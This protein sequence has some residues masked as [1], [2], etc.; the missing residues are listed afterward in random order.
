M[1]DPGGLAITRITEFDARGR[2]VKSLMPK[3]NGTD[4]GTQLTTP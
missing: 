2:A 1:Q 4:P 3:S